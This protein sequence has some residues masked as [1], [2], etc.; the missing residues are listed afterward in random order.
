M[1]RQVLNS[2]KQTNKTQTDK[3]QPNTP[4]DRLDQNLASSVPAKK[5]G[6]HKRN[7]N[8]YLNYIWFFLY[9]ILHANNLSIQTLNVPLKINDVIRH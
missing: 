7:N 9:G 1:E 6:S 8:K 3:T 2:K 5:E 4:T